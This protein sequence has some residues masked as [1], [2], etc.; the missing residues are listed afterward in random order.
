MTNHELTRK[1][2]IRTK[3]KHGFVKIKLFSINVARDTEIKQ[4][5]RN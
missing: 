5:S 2:L 4:A 1:P 3:E